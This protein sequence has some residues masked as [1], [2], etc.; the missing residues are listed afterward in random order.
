[1]V[2]P[3]ETV[4]SSP[5]SSAIAQYSGHEDLVIFNNEYNKN[6]FI[7]VCSSIEESVN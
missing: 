7:I 4:H 5:K 6:I 2:E 1:M 3:R